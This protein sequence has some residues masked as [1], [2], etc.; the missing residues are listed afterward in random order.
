M[1]SQPGWTYIWRI[2]LLCYKYTYIYTHIYVWVYSKCCSHAFFN[3]SVMVTSFLKFSARCNCPQEALLYFPTAQIPSWT[4]V[5]GALCWLIFDAP[6]LIP[7]SYTHEELLEHWRSIK[8][9]MNRW[10]EQRFNAQLA[11]VKCF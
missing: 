11:H 7:S 6:S 5:N 4:E 3:P 10:K 9:V 8:H 2:L 1:L